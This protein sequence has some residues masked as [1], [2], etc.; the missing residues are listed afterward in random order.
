MSKRKHQSKESQDKTLKKEVPNKTAKQSEAKEVPLSNIVI[1]AIE[2]GLQKL[3]SQ[4]FKVESN[5]M[6]VVP[7]YSRYLV[8]PQVRYPLDESH[9]LKRSYVELPAELQGVVSLLR[10]SKLDRLID[11]LETI[12]DNHFFLLECKGAKE[13]EL[14]RSKDYRDLTELFVETDVRYQWA[15]LH[16]TASTSNVVSELSTLS[17]YEGSISLFLE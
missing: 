8:P 3:V 12:W 16:S 15:Q 1:E 6:A 7:G 5:S 17:I 14:G 4:L 11:V 2:Q 10:G 13:G 9:V